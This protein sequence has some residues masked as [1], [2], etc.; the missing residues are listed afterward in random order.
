VTECKLE[1]GSTT[2]YGQT[3]PCAQTVG[4]GTSNVAVSG[5][6]GSLSPRT[7]YH[8]R[9]VAKN[10]GGTSTGADE[11]LE[12]LSNAPTVKTEPASA[13]TQTSATLNATVNPNGVEV[14]ECKF[15]YGTTTAYGSS[16]SCS[17]APGSGTSSVP[18]SAAI[19]SLTANTTYHF[20]I[21]A[22]NAG[23]T[24]TGLDQT[25]NTLTTAPEF[26]RCLKVAAGTGK[27]GNAAC[28]Q[29]GGQR[30]Y[31]WFP[32][33]V[34]K[35]FTTALAKG[36]VTFETVKGTKLTCKGESG[37]GE[38]SGTKTIGNVVLKF[39]ECEQLGQKCSSQGALEGQVETKALEGVLGFI[40][41]T[42]SLKR[43]GL[44]LFP[45]GKAGAFMEFSCGGFAGSI[46]GG[47][48]VP[49]TRNIMQTSTKFV[50]VAS[51]GKQTPE[52]FESQ[53]KNV[54]EASFALSPFEQVGLTLEVTL[55]NQERVEMNSVV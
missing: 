51:K 10:A 20:R 43:I 44:A 45:V 36:G 28:T 23:G 21:L 3:A 25:L 12:T 33:V 46:R 22:T 53:P 41:S 24:S 30:T 31:E 52:S 26:G 50:F 19:G 8:F 48:I 15:E 14:T 5:A 35:A 55:A 11:T 40:K 47:V 1:F 34:K 4:S 2:A 9:I 18:V 16:A 17:P 49:A 6:V 7:T 27:Y 32:G 39:S 54:L 37:T 38:Y 13:V 29:A 42:E